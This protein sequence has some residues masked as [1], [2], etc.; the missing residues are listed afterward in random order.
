[1][2]PEEELAGR[3]PMYPMSSSSNLDLVLVGASRGRTQCSSAD[4]GWAFLWPFYLPFAIVEFAERLDD[5]KKSS[6]INS[7]KYPKL[8]WP[9]YFQL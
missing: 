5:L 6:W 2:R 3:Y 9:Y 7:Q 1:V 8:Y 4:I